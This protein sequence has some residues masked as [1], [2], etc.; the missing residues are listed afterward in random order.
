MCNASDG[1]KTTL[2]DYSRSAQ[3]IVATLVTG[4]SPCSGQTLFHVDRDEKHRCKSC[5]HQDSLG[6]TPVGF[7]SDLA[8]KKLGQK[9]ADGMIAWQLHLA[10]MS[11]SSSALEVVCTL[12][13]ANP[14]AA[15]AYDMDGLLPLDLACRNPSRGRYLSA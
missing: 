8:P 5:M 6:V 15:A 2:E 14:L 12:L 4:K 11:D 9:D 7:A 10:V 3:A 1:S 13:E